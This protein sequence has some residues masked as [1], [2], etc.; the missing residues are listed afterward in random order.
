MIIEDDPYWNLQYG[1]STQTAADFLK[2]LVPSFLSLD[3]DGRV[4][5]LDTFS[6]TIAPGCRLGWITAQ[7]RICEQLIRLTDAT[8]QQP[9][10]ISQAIV[11]QLLR[12]TWGM[13]GWARWL[14]KLQHNYRKRMV[15]MATIFQEGR[16][17]QTAS[18][19][20]EM[21]SFNWPMGGMFLWVKV[22]LQLHPLRGAVDSERLMQALWVLCTQEP[23][24][25]LSNP[26]R[27]FA[28]NETIR[29]ERAHLYLRFCFASV[30]E[31]ILAQKSR[32]FVEA[33]QHF[34]TFQ[35]PKDI[36]RI[37]VDEDQRRID[38]AEESERLVL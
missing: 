14:E 10:G 12:S 37:L 17:T 13:D 6:K 8:S 24:R 34:W 35:E 19:P 25:V 31:G 21:F 16:Q 23:Y 5:R 7:P 9:S 20:V 27:D 32:S 38:L 15:T 26:G 29:K 11:V 30:G 28:A 33:C 18:G 4:I 2:T 1:I 36:D 22:E 3:V